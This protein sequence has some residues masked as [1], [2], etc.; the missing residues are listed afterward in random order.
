[1]ITCFILF[2]S[3]CKCILLL[4]RRCSQVYPTGVFYFVYYLQNPD[5]KIPGKLPVESRLQL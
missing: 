2:F 4:V 5:N 3:N 1:M